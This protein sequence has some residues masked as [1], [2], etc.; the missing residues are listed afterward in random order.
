MKWTRR[1][2]I[3]G[4]ICLSA[5]VPATAEQVVETWR[6]P[7][8]LPRGLSV[9]SADGSCWA[10]TGNTVMHVGA[11]GLVLHQL[12]GL[13]QPKAVSVDRTDGSCWVA[14]TDG[15]L[16]SRY[17]ASGA[18]LWSNAAYGRPHS[19]SANPTD[20]SCWV[21]GGPFLNMVFHVGPDGST[22]WYGTG[23]VLPFSV[24]VNSSDSSCWVGA[25]GRADTSG[26]YTDSAAIHLAADGTE[27][28]RA[29]GLN[30]VQA[31]AVNPADGSCWALDIAPN[32][33][34]HL[35]AAGAE[36]W[37]GGAFS[38][39]EGLAVNPSDGSCWVADTRD[40]QVVHL[41]STGSELWRSATGTLSRPS[42]IEANPADGSCWVGDETSMEVVHLAADGTVLL[43]CGYLMEPMSVSVDPAD[44]ACWVADK[45]RGAVLRLGPDGTEL[46]RG[47]GFYSPIQAVA[48][49]LDGSCWVADAGQG[50]LIRGT[51]IH[52]SQTGTELFRTGT[53]AWPGTTSLF[54]WEVASVSAA[55]GSCWVV[56]SYNE[57]VRHLAANG[58]ELW[59]G[60]F[61]GETHCPSVNPLDGSVW[62]NSAADLLHLAADGTQLFSTASYYIRPVVDGGDG[63]CWVFRH[64]YSIAATVHLGPDGVVL[65]YSPTLAGTPL[66]VNP[67][68]GSFWIG[69]LYHFSREGVEL[70]VYPLPTTRLSASVSYRDNVVWIADQ[71]NAQVARLV[72]LPDPGADF[73]AFPRAGSA[74]LRVDF[75]ERSGGAAA[76]WQW[77]FGDGTTS[78]APAPSHTYAAPGRYTVTL[79]AAGAF[80]EDTET[81]IELVTVSFPDVPPAYWAWRPVLDCVAAGIVSG[82]PDGT[83]QP[84]VSVTR[85]QMA[86]YIARSLVIP[87]GDAAIPDPVPPATFSD[88]PST[89]WAYKHIEYAVSQNVVKGYD[90]GTYK[91]DL[92]VDRGQMAV[93][94]ARAIATPTAGADL[95]NYTPAATATFPD[96]PTKFWAYKYVE[97]IAQASV[98]VT[99]GYPDGTYHP[100][101]V[102]TRDQMAVYVA[103]AFKLPM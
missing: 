24:S 13:A 15:A 92:V 32:Q 57:E 56:D 17:D 100:E 85:D 96:V 78:T 1:L 66:A 20:G 47:S 91:P 90:D 51:L 34:V 98:A 48:S 41:S 77:D 22:L 61:P 46:W 65:W 21:S 64:A 27:L 8:G 45:G 26:N 67:L 18:L 82:Y 81:K 63:S 2:L 59:R 39:P 54:G 29:S 103:R 3:V 101:Y 44:G 52:L 36:L 58:V 53:F 7:W 83:Y 31:V 102:C 99:K 68:D 74:P 30:G 4:V 89:H 35:S 79:V 60:T 72:V 10:A 73:T 70:S 14:N 28:G 43:R 95:V 33:V 11:A 23:F 75:A 37:R 49:P 87:T 42:T 25:R 94:I 19:V 40:G 84:S 16:L 62:L 38:G 71:T 55:D 97:Y 6:S 5:A 69:N 93:F 86:V 88:V 50:I 12:S 80:G 9:N 76:S